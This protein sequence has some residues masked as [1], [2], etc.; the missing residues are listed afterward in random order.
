MTDSANVEVPVV[1]KLTMSVVGYTVSYDRGLNLVEPLEGPAELV[2][3]SSPKL[4]LDVRGATVAH[5]D[6][7]PIKFAAVSFT[8][9]PFDSDRVGFLQEV[10]PFIS[11]IAQLPK[12]DFPA[13]CA[14]LCL[15]RE[16]TLVC[17]I[18]L[19]PDEVGTDRVLRLN[20]RR[21]RSA[22]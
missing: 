20:V 10:G 9:G 2:V 1:E 6:N 14:A 19:G 21:E 7:R 18:A 16:A 3:E 12:A 11:I 5:H 17:N 4:S 13:F 22:N 8:E 15:E